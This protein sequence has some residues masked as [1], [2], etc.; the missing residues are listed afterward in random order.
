MQTTS[1]ACFLAKRRSPMTV[2]CSPSIPAAAGLTLR[3]AED[4]KRSYELRPDF[5]QARFGVDKSRFNSAYARNQLL[6][7]WTLSAVTA[8]PGSIS[9]LAGAAGPMADEGPPGIF[10]R[11][12]CQAFPLTFAQDVAMP[13]P[14]AAIAARSTEPRA[15]E[16]I[17]RV[18]R[19]S[20]SRPGRDD[21]KSVEAAKSRLI[22]LSGPP[23]TS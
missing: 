6:P 14:P 11:G 22:S 7:R 19:H 5:Q 17:H 9:T 3:V 2:L 23:T 8:T 1:C 16:R 12:K 21:R 4:L 13:A 15:A 10:R 20:G 18:E